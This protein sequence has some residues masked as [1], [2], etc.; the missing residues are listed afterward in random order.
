MTLCFGGV[1]V[2]T[3]TIKHVEGNMQ[4][5]MGVNAHVLIC[6]CLRTSVVS[7][8]AVARGLH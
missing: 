1:L 4:S 3:V 7:T 5:C 2:P 8:S 6:Q